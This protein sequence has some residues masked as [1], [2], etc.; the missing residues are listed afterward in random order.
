MPP[1]PGMRTSSI[2]QS[3]LASWSEAK[4]SSAE[5]NALTANPSDLSNPERASR[6]DSSS[7]TTE[8]RWT[9]TKEDDHFLRQ[10]SIIPWY[11]C[12]RIGRVSPRPPGI[13]RTTA[14]VNERQRRAESRPGQRQPIPRFILRVNIPEATL[15]DPG[16]PGR[17]RPTHASA[18]D[19]QNPTSTQAAP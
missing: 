13:Q 7:S 6:T 15:L 9:A 12:G 10:V 18:A 17:T 4:N 5:A 2:R 11:K 19:R 8:I 1:I 16:G 3:A 14:N